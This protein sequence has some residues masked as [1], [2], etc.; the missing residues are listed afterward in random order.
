MIFW[1]SKGFKNINV[2]KTSE[3][4]DLGF[5]FLHLFVSLDSETPF[6]SAGYY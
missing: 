5:S 4:F 3:M 1:A 6:I 2:K